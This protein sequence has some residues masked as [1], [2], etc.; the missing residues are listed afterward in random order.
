MANDCSLNNNKKRNTFRLWRFSEKNELS[1]L[2]DLEIVEDRHAQSNMKKHR[3]V[4][5]LSFIV[6]LRGGY[7]GNS[8]HRNSTITNVKKHNNQQ[9]TYKRET[10]QKRLGRPTT[11]TSH[12][13]SREF[14][15][16]NS[17]VGEDVNAQ[18]LLA[19]KN[20]SLDFS[21]FQKFRNFKTWPSWT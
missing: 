1:K 7:T 19:T 12:S 9:N 2:T 18:W 3:H 13:T 14:W 20:K 11:Q 8:D 6:F 5:I 4:L 10:T 17:L 21:D 15:F 16:C